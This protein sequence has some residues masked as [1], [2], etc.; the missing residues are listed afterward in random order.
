MTPLYN[1]AFVGAVGLAD[2]VE[3]VSGKVVPALLTPLTCDPLWR[4]VVTG[5]KFDRSNG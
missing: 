2:C 3:L 1:I 4:S 5:L